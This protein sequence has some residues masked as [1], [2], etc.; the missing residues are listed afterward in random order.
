MGTDSNITD[1][2]VL[3]TMSPI[4]MLSRFGQLRSSTRRFSISVVRHR[5]ESFSRL[6]PVDMD[7]EG[8]SSNR[9][10]ETEKEIKKPILHSYNFIEDQ[11][12]GLACDEETCVKLDPTAA[13]AI[14]NPLPPDHTYN[15]LD[16]MTEGQD[17]STLPQ[18]DLGEESKEQ[19]PLEHTYNF[20]EDMHENTAA[21][22]EEPSV[23]PLV[24]TYSFLDDM[25]VEDE[26]EMLK[27]R[28]KLPPS[29]TFNFLDDVTE[30]VDLDSYAGNEKLFE[31]GSKKSW[32]S[33]GKYW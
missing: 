22:L 3:G 6:K 21:Q 28:D 7:S 19:E 17:I 25:T 24:H 32:F 8:W 26:A 2:W 30:G 4:G 15:F 27:G 20:L 12:E 18:V 1:G 29:H 5:Q 9:H 10:V 31:V 33:S 11:T 14:L 16:D 13:P 23:E